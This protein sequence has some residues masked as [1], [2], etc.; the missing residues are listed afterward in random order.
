MA[1]NETKAVM[2]CVRWLHFKAIPDSCSM[3][4]HQSGSQFP[5]II[6]RASLG[7]GLGSLQL[8]YQV[9]F[10]VTMHQ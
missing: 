6:G 8:T 5:I 1:G 3:Q 2:V 4:K 7:M 9:G 10:V